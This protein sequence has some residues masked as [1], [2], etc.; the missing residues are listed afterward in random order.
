MAD[1]IKI[2][3]DYLNGGGSYRGLAKKY[4]VSFNTLKARAD[5][6][7]WKK[8]KDL[9]E[10]VITTAVQQKIIEKTTDVV[11]DIG[12]LQVEI[13]QEIYAQIARRIRANELSNADFRRL[14]QC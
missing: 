13:K 6:E 14:V 3:E 10:K 4:N 12:V 7:S 11:A 1:W 2:R 8:E 5:R 9:R